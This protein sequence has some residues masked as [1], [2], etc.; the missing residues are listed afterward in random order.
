MIFKGE[1]FLLNESALSG[2]TCVLPTTLS[3]FGVLSYY[4][5]AITTLFLVLRIAIMQECETG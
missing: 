5:S 4:G 2:G 1:C 3:F